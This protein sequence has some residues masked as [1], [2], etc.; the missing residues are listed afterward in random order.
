MLETLTSYM[1]HIA[2]SAIIPNAIS[3]E[4]VFEYLKDH[5]GYAR[6]GKDL[7]HK[8]ITLERKPGEKMRAYWSRF[9]AFFEE[10]HIKAN[11]KL[12]VDEAKAT[13]TDKQCRY[14]IGSE[15]VLFLHIRAGQF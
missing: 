6:S 13:E 10:N 2:A 5:Y 3:L 1:P 4:W 8:F 15:L 7:M 14:G 12:K 9:Q 11:D